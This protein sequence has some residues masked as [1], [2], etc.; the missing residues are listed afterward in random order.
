M[1]LPSMAVPVVQL[2]LDA[3]VGRIKSARTMAR[4]I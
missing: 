4:L 3:S 2:L 1:K